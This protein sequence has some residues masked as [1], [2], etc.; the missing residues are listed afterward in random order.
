MDDN[1]KNIIVISASI[2]YI[3]EYWVSQSNIQKYSKEQL[4]VYLIRI[5]NYSPSSEAGLFN[6]KRK[7]TTPKLSI[8]GVIQIVDRTK[9]LLHCNETYIQT[10]IIIANGC[11]FDIEAHYFKRTESNECSA[12][13]IWSINKRIMK[14]KAWNL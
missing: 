13:R 11:I 12:V 3:W 5:R 2:L 14:I 6:F 1:I 8:D 9:L 4:S 10:I 7:M